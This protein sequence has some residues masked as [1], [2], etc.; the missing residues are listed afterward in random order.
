VIRDVFLN[1]PKYLDGAKELAKN[2]KEK[3]GI[4]NMTKVFDSLLTK[5]DIY[6]KVQPKLKQINLPELK[7]V[8]LPKLKKIEL[9]KL[10]KV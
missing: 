9:P 2:N 6:N 7:K 4:E 3:F 8:E 5:Y 1:Y 10:K